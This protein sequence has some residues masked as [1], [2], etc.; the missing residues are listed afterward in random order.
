MFLLLS[1]GKT[2][3]LLR[4]HSYSEIEQSTNLVTLLNSGWLQINKRKSS[5]NIKVDRVEEDE[6]EERDTS[7][8]SSSQDY[9]DSLETKVD[10]LRLLDLID[11]PDTYASKENKVLTVKGDATGI[12]FTDLSSG[13][14][15]LNDIATDVTI[16][17]PMN[18]ESLVYDE[19]TSQWVNK[20]NPEQITH[21]SSTPYTLSG[22]SGIYLVD[23]TSGNIAVN[24]PESD[25]FNDGD[26]IRVYKVS[27]DSNSVTVQVTA[28]TQDVGGDSE[29]EITQQT[30]GFSVVSDYNGGVDSQWQ[31]IQDSRFLGGTTEGSLQYWD[32]TAGAWTETGTSLRFISG[33]NSIRL[34]SGSDVNAVLDEDNMAS[35]SAT[36]LATQ[37]S[38]K[39]YADTK[40]ATSSLLDEDNF[41]SNSATQPASQQSIKAYVDGNF[42]ADSELL[43]E[44]NF[45]SDSATQPASQQ[46]IK[47]YVDGNF[48]AQS[49]LL[50][51]DSFTSNSA[52]QP[53]SQQSIKYYIDNNFIADAE[54][55]DEDDMSSDLDTRPPTQQSVKAYVDNSIAAIATGLTV[56]TKTTTYTATNNDDVILCDIS[57]GAWTLTLPAAT[58]GKIFYIKK[59]DSTAYALT[60]DGNGS[61]T[62]DGDLTLILTEQY[63][64]LKLISDGSDWYIF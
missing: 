33:T 47:A 50:D 19:N 34:N 6:V 51:E 36:S 31:I 39:A 42:I 12:I 64:S 5:T 22:S 57:G 37:Q 61:E 10:T 25:E 45:A 40:I 48:I 24:L 53:A 8:L 41:A 38:I 26:R 2:V 63:T 14:G 13:G 49:D 20:A 18:N 55:I 3:D 4:H 30:K 32:N 27:S 46:S 28:K 15:A 59:T 52:T 43:D 44:D 1:R 62:I 16:S 7:T 17:S 56:T 54:L 23:S 58:S 35:N 21:V 9:T 60:I 11:V 29:Q